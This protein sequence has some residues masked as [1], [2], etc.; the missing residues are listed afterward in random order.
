VRWPSGAVDTLTNVP[1]NRVVT[2]K[3]GKGLVE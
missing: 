2:V 1:V 3:E